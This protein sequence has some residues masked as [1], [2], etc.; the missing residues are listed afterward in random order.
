MSLIVLNGGLQTTIQA[1]QRARQR[2]WG[3]PTSGPADTL[4][5]ALANRLVGNVLD[6]AALEITLS[7]ASFQFTANSLIAL[8]GGEA[9]I[10]LNAVIY[11]KN[12]TLS[13]K[14][15]DILELAP[16]TKGA[17]LYF[18]IA[19]GIEGDIWLGSVSTY[20][21]AGRG[22]YKGRALK[23]G[24]TL[25]MGTECGFNLNQPILNVP[26]NLRPHIGSSW[27]LR[28]CTGPEAD[29]L[30]PSAQALFYETT[31]HVSNRASR[32]G[33]AL[34][35]QTLALAS[36][37]RMPSAAVF[38]G[39]VQCPPSGQPFLLMADAGTTGGYPRIAQIIRADRHMLGQLRPGDRVQFKRATP[40]EAAHVLMEKTK[41]L[42]NWLG[43]TFHLR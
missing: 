37:G 10:R 18:A 32:M 40:Q 36:D 33:L 30:A 6:A 28:A 22:G 27:M 24:D 39:T 31:F 15:G 1:G 19:G 38:P 2:H 16:L 8:A 29:L 23:T 43:D 34:E 42:R 4:S 11:P 13:V 20:L 12:T 3:V 9:E 41:L 17:R 35:G 21:P 26:H 5:H 25:K 7:G 14:A